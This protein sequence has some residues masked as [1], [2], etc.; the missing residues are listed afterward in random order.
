M[1]KKD[2]LEN[3]KNY[4]PSMFLQIYQFTEDELELFIDDVYVYQILYTQKNLSYEFVK[5]YILNENYHACDKDEYI[6][7][8]EVIRC[9]PHLSHC[10]DE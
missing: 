7:E 3:T 6:D 9:Q 4:E 5:K 10:F 1:S 2:F 8:D